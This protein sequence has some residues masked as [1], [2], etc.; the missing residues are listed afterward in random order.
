MFM[1]L[2]FNQGVTKV[3]S[4]L[5]DYYRYWSLNLKNVITLALQKLNVPP[6]GFITTIEIVVLLLGQITAKKCMLPACGWCWKEHVQ[7][8]QGE[9]KLFCSGPQNLRSVAFEWM[10]MQVCC[11]LLLLC[12]RPLKPKRC[13]YVSDYENYKTIKLELILPSI[14]KV[15]FWQLPA[16][17]Y[18]T[19]WIGCFSFHNSHNCIID[20][21][22]HFVL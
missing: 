2:M 11:K 4:L 7:L 8:K 20:A 10:T 6:L 18:A 3:I 14:N 13:L 9:L 21:A 1:R 15:P 22:S 5:W 17:S 19:S 12:N 16:D